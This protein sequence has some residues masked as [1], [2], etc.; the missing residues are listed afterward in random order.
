MLHKKGQDYLLRCQFLHNLFMTYAFFCVLEM[1][2]LGSKFPK[3]AD[4][5]GTI[6]LVY[7]MIK[8]TTENWIE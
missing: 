6:A 8:M 1:Q 2:V 7:G 4:P 5:L 3:Y